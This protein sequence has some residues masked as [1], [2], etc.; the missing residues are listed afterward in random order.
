MR[1]RGR[2]RN[3]RVQPKSPNHASPQKT[4]QV[5]ERQSL[6]CVRTICSGDWTQAANAEQESS[7]LRS[8]K[9][10]RIDPEAYLRCAA[11]KEGP[12]Y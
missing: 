1:K 9:L 7:L 2:T 4:I 12:E 8:A 5:F 3:R 10:N 6:W 11:I